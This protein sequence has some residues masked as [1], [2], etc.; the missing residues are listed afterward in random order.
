MEVAQLLLPMKFGCMMTCMQVH[1]SQL[2]VSCNSV[3]FSPPKQCICS[4]LDTIAMTNHEYGQPCIHAEL[5]Q[6]D[7]AVLRLL[8]KHPSLCHLTLLPSQTYMHHTGPTASSM[9]PVLHAT[10]CY[11]KLQH[12]IITWNATI[13]YWCSIAVHHA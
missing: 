4:I 3:C 2:H 6:S 10:P 11:P 12:W 1:Y 7:H 5:D 9:P 13:F 8:L